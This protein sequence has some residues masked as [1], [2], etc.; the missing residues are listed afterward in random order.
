MIGPYQIIPTWFNFIFNKK[1]IKKLLHLMVQIIYNALITMSAE[2][3][4]RTL[5]LTVNNV[6]LWVQANDEMRRT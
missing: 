1:N 5:G 3:G 2:P 4:P 6:D